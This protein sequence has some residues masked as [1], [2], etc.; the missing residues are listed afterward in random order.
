[1]NR[2]T[3]IFLSRFLQAILLL[4]GMRLLTSLLPENQVG[5]YY[6]L[7]SIFSYAGLVL[8]NPIGM[9]INRML[10]TWR[11]EGSL[12]FF[13]KTYNTYLLIVAFITAI[14][15]VLFRVSFHAG[16]DIPILG[17]ALIIVFFVYIN[18]WNT[19]LVPTL[20]MF[21]YA[22]PFV[23]LSNA[24]LLLGLTFSSILILSLGKTAEGWI[25]GQIGGMCIAAMIAAVYFVKRENIK[26]QEER[27]KGKFKVDYK[28]TARFAL[29]LAAATAGIWLQQQSYRLVVAGSLGSAAL[30][31]MAVGFSVA[32]SINSAVESIGT[33]IANP[34]F[35]ANVSKGDQAARESAWAK[36]ANFLFPLFI[37]TFLYIACAGRSLLVLLTGPAFHG[38]YYYVVLG[39]CIEIIRVFNN[40]LSSAAHAE[41]KTKWLVVPHLIGGL[42][43]F[44]GAILCRNNTNSSILIPL[45]LVI[46]ILITVI[47]NYISVKNKF[48]IR[49]DGFRM[50]RFAVRSL[51]FIPMVFL[52]K[53]GGGLLLSLAVCGIGGLYYLWILRSLFAEMNEG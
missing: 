48:A 35:Y 36:Y 38:A 28:A 11:T 42:A 14:I 31:Q 29:P 3:L 16:A 45:V 6:I 52:S 19:T 1:M 18:T 5:N 43:A 53:L 17:F 21:G 7:Q 9:Y 10:F 4:V 12:G 24:S 27:K 32:S 33:Q 34:A 41:L 2:T 44:G 22:L 25:W 8:I 37:V 51:P 26:G 50:L 15:A 23:V 47:L 49:L 30:A 40:V 39:A 13:T 46:S 20:N